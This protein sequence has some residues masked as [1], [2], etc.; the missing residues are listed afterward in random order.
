MT[1]KL[2]QIELPK[3]WSTAIVLYGVAA[4]LVGGLAAWMASPILSAI[5]IHSLVGQEAKGYWDISRATGVVAYLLFWLSMMMGLLVSTRTTRLWSGTQSFLALHEFTSIT[6]L[7]LTGIHALVL[8]GDGFI[9]TDWMHI[10]VPFAMQLPKATQ[11]VWVGL[12]QIGFYL[13]LVILLSF[14]VRKKIGYGMWRWLHFGTFVAFMSSTV[15]GMLAGSDSQ[16]GFMLVLYGLTTGSILF[17]TL[18]RL[19]LMHV[20]GA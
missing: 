13:L 3:R 12:G 10:I 16:S 8:L 18:Y 9:D 19:L 5:F 17:L 7:V 1:H 15:H 11:S 14:Y 20:K 4:L 6:G 2:T